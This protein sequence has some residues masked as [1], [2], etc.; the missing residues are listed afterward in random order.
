M[1]VTPSSRI[2]AFDIGIKNLAY[3]VLDTTTREVLAV[4]NVNLLP[5]VEPLLCMSCKLKASFMAGDR[6][7][8]RRHVPKTHTIRAEWTAKKKPTNKMLRDWVKEYGR[9]AT[10]TSNDACLAALSGVLAIPLPQPKQANAAKVSLEQLHDAIHGFVGDHWVLFSGCT[11]VLLE[12]QPAFKNPH[13]K[14]VQVLLFATLREA[15]MRHSRPLPSFHLVHAGKKTKG[16]QAG[17]AGYA[18]RKET[19]ERRVQEAVAEGLLLQGEWYTHW[20][21]ATKKSD[22]ADA[23]CMCMDAGDSPVTE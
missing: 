3:A 13:M 21:A 1:S 16:V 8:C 5:P 22:M 6:R 15:W 7:C 9:T 10:G 12:N 19:S 20:C 14:S 18:Q 17:D 2:L 11:K 23:L 4:E